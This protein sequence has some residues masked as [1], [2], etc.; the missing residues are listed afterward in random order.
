MIWIFLGALFGGIALGLPIA[1]AMLLSATIVMT[2]TGAFDPQVL[3][4]TFMNGAN[5]FALMAIPFFILTGEVM[6]AGGVSKRIVDFAAAFVGH[7]RGG[8]GF[9]VIIAGVIF[10]GIS[11]SAVA[12]TAAL[13]AILIPMLRKHGYDLRNSSGL[14]ASSGLI[15]TIL[16]PSI[17]MILFGVVGGVSIT[18][19]F[20]SGIFPGLLMGLG[21]AIVWTF[22]SKRSSA[23]R[24]PR[25]SWKERLSATYRA[26]PALFLPLLIIF[27]LRGGIFTPTE[28]GVMAAVY[29]GILGLIYRELSIKAVGKVLLSAANTTGV[30]LFLAAA[31]MVC[32]HAITLAQ[33]PA[34]LQMFLMNIS[35]NPTVILLLIMV[36]LFAVGCVMDMTPAILIFTPVLL[37]IV[38]NLGIDP[39]YFGIIMVMNLSIGLMTPPVGTVL[40]GLFAVRGE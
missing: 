7:I 29:A 31:A 26:L 8:L 34:S 10:A 17:P 15:G 36:I 37:P 18:Q 11:G 4:D 30:V 1:A 13:G 40:Y 21:L 38:T 32:G 39:V 20:M 2:I 33:V 19:L 9:V 6:N 16:P 14:L 5:S 35:D 3:A 27:G 25:M 23:A 28:A 12:D 22:I 24:L